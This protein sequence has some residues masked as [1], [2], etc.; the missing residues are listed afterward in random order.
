M[1]PAREI[2]TRSPYRDVGAVH[3]TYIQSDPIEWE[4]P[5]EE[6]FIHLALPCPVVA[7]IQFQPF[8]LF[9]LDS[10]GKER[11]HTPDFLL[12]LHSGLRLVVEVKTTKFIKKNQEK[13]DK[14]AALMRQSDA[15]YYVITEK[16]LD[17]HRED[18]ANVW[19]RYARVAAPASQVA[20]A[21]TMV[22]ESEAGRTVQEFI[23]AGIAIETLYHL[24]G[25]R[26]L[27][28]GLDLETTLTTTLNFPEQGAEHER[29]QFDHWFD[30]AAWGAHVPT[31]T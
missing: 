18:R 1:K 15:W 25:R 31:G 26:V 21:L 7:H 4:S 6:A 8:T 20:A 30:C 9:Y 5:W 24:L 11:E 13:F 2:V 10:L 12:K 28:A 14:S 29:L 19:R 16:Q 23:D 27:R 22:R 3:A 17:L